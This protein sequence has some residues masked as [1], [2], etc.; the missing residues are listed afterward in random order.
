MH[1]S[2]LAVQR[3]CMPLGDIRVD[4]PPRALRQPMML[5]MDDLRAITEARARANEP[6]RVEDLATLVF[7]RVSRDK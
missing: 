2:P 4:G 3:R 7:G 6:R 5:G 1:Y